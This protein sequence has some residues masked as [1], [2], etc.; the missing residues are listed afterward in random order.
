MEPKAKLYYDINEVA[1]LLKVEAPTLRF[2][3]KKFPQLDPKRDA[4]NRRRY[5]ERDIEIIKKIMHQ[6]DKQGRTIKGTREQ[7]R[8]KEES[9]LMIQRLMRVRKFLV[10][11]KD[12]L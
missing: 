12:N 3:E 8:R 2:W 4:R 11:L 7:L 5:T 9:E 6:R 1:E 10:E